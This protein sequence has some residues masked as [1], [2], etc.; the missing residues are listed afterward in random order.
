MSLDRHLC[1]AERMLI[2]LIHIDVSRSSM[3][4]IEVPFL[5]GN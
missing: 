5:H 2:H 4:G 3:V 1:K